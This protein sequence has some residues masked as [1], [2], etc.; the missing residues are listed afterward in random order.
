MK[1]QFSL[2]LLAALTNA[3]ALPASE[4]NEFI[5]FAA[6]YNKHYSTTEELADRIDKWQKNKDKVKKLN[7]DNAGTGVS[8][9]I[10]ETGDL[11]AEEFHKR[12]GL[13]M[14]HPKQ[15]PVGKKAK[16]E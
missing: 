4:Q 12:Q 8:F 16:K 14:D 11:S 15:K 7:E 13:D 10:N 5:G 2:A 6:Q 9:K 1:T 3:G